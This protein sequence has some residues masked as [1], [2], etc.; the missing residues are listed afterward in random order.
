[1]AYILKGSTLTAIADAIRAKA[2]I[3]GGMTPLQMP[4]KIA[5]I[6]T[7]G[8][9]AIN[10]PNITLKVNLGLDEQPFP[11]SISL[12]QF[13]DNKIHPFTYLASELMPGAIDGVFEAPLTG[14]YGFSANFNGFCYY[15][16]ISRKQQGGIEQVLVDTRLDVTNDFVKVQK[17]GSFYKIV[18]IDFASAGSPFLNG[19]IV[20]IAFQAFNFQWIASAYGVNT[21]V[22]YGEF[23]TSLS[24]DVYITVD[25][26]T[27]EESPSLS[28]GC[29]L[30]TAGQSMYRT[31]TFDIY[32]SGG[33]VT[34]LDRY[35]NTVLCMGKARIQ[36]L[37]TNLLGALLR[38]E[39]VNVS[40]N[41]L[42]LVVLNN[43]NR[44][45]YNALPL[46]VAPP[47]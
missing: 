11:L 38:P 36:Q 4:A 27:S 23:E 3:T 35:G 19:D 37:A 5:G 47:S 17:Y 33:V 26:Y 30:T 6:S 41:T 22:R 44:E 9:G 45:D 39:N 29:V 15:V 31:P 2:G 1:M 43:E 46:L 16:K 20:D 7:G 14:A 32:D 12:I 8:G 18:S 24:R 10:A 34:E 25:N 28:L 40:V 21:C 13:M 42:E